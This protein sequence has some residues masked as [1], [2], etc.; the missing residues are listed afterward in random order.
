M[1]LGLLERKVSMSKVKEFKAGL[2]WFVVTNATVEC[3]SRI[4]VCWNR[5]RCNVDIQEIHTH[6]VHIAYI[7]RT[8]VKFILPLYMGPVRRQ[9]GGICG[10][11]LKD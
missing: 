10:N 9:R 5:I 7:G 8:R 3:K 11:I 2:G 6:F 4:W 1:V